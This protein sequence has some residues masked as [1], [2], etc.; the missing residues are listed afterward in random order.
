M[1]PFAGRLHGFAMLSAIFILV[2]LATLGAFIVSVSTNQQTGFALDVQGVRGYQAARAGIEWGLYQ[3]Q[4]SPGYNFGYTSTDPN[5]RSCFVS[6]TS[7]TPVAP[8][9]SGFRVTV[10][11]SAT[12]APGGG[13]TI[14]VV[15]AV[16][17]SQP[18]AGSCPNTNSPGSLYV[19][20]RLDVSF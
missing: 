12:L 17:C 4:A 8:M 6:P 15:T 18:D 16:A 19:E 2:V 3:V 20:R 1:K 5:T 10:T 13:P 14:Y 9:L 11:C 7:F